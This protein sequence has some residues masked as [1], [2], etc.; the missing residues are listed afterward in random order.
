MNYTSCE[1]KE[2][3]TVE[4]IVAV[5]R[6]ELN[7]AVDGAFRK[8][9]S[10]ISVP[11]FRRGKAPRKIIERLYGASIFHNDAIEI[12]APQVIS[13]AMKEAEVKIVSLPQIKDVDFKDDDEGADFT[14]LAAVYPEVTVGEYKGLSA[15]KPVTDVADSEI[16][17]ELAGMQLRNARIEK[18]ERPAINGDTAVIDY[19]GFIDDEPFEG[20]KGENYELVLGS[21]TFIPGFEEKIHGMLTGEER[22]LDLVFPE[23]YSEDLAGKQVIFKVKL[24]ELRE[25]ILPELDDE[26][27]KDVSEFDTLGEYKASIREKLLVSKEAD[28]NAR[29]ENALMEKLVLSV[30][31][32]IPDAMIEDQLDNAVS[33]FSSQITAYGM[34]PS[35]YLKMMNTTPA[36]FRENMRSQSENQVKISLALNKI[37]ELEGIE[38]SDEDIENEYKEAAERYGMEVEDLKERT[39]AEDISIDIKLRLAAKI[40]TENAVAEDPP[41][42]STE[43][44]DALPEEAGEAE[45]QPE[46][47]G[48][49]VTVKQQAGKSGDTAGAAV[50]AKKAAPKKSPAKAKSD[51]AQEADQKIA[52]EQDSAGAAEEHAGEAKVTAD[53][54][55]SAVSGEEGADASTAAPK[56]KAARKTSAKA[57]GED[58][59]AGKSETVSAAKPKKPAAKAVK[60]EDPEV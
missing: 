52:A 11:G 16:D 41:P 50:K 33:N 19:E 49:A 37:A 21:N 43:E 1:K 25:K 44:A 56:K 38:V 9:R 32:D 40:V 20:G 8:N 15:V 22:D 18:T 58:P 57:P 51:K 42:E 7:T 59:G 24:N 35:A 60:P 45:N 29:F 39:T 28:A 3:S 4:I 17:S 53:S 36:A 54:S 48:D 10:S 34:E 31:A 55:D 26:F 5:D 6:E 47:A 30:E 13:F 14:I 46:E 27:A 2:K 23:N 12:L